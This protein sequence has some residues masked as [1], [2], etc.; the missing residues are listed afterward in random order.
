[1]HVRIRSIALTGLISLLAC[2]CANQ[3]PLAYRDA[4]QIPEGPGLFSGEEG[5]FRLGV[6]DLGLVSETGSKA[7]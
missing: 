1:M 7:Q 6:I 4:N 2:G 3:T 5:E